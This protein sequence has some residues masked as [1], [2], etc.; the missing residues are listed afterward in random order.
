MPSHAAG[1]KIGVSARMKP[2]V[3]EVVAD[4]VDDLVADA[5]D[6]LLA[7]RADPQVAVIHQEVDAVLLRRD[8]IVLRFS[9]DLEAGDVDL[10][11]AGRARVGAGRAGH[12]QRRLLRQVIGAAERLFAD[13]RLRHDA[14]D[15]A[16]P[17]AQRQEV[18]LAARPAVVQPAAERHGLTTWLRTLPRA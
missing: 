13:C 8:R 11:A 17:V 16:G 7:R 6:R 2:R 4:G 9:D 14:L 3:V 12:R 15:E 10:V 18:N 1:V 5:E